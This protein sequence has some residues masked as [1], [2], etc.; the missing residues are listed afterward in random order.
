MLG[1]FNPLPLLRFKKGSFTSLAKRAQRDGLAFPEAHHLGR[2][3]EAPGAAAR[4]TG[5]RAHGRNRGSR[6]W[7]KAN[8][9]QQHGTDTGKWLEGSQFPNS[10]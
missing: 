4:S 5:A 7:P 1:S 2:K 3:S 8:R 10:S 6:Q 9:L